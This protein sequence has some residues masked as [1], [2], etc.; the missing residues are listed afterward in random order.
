MNRL[1]AILITLNEERNLPR[2]LDSLA[3][4]PDEILVVDAGSTD[5]TREIAI[6]RGARVTER[7]WTNYSDQRNFAASQA[8]FDWILALDADEQLSPLLLD[9][10]RAWRLRPPAHAAY[11]FPRRARYLGKWIR[12]SGWYPD[13]KTRLYDRRRARFVGLV[14]EAVQSDGPVGQLVGDLLHYAYETPAEHAAKVEAYTTIAAQ[15]LFRAAKR[16]WFLPMLLV[17]LWTLV[18]KFILRAGFL[19]GWRGWRIARM[20]ARYAWLKFKKLGELVRNAKP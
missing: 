8:R 18:Q 2:A 19:D 20:S 3:D 16:S 7:A 12:H 10:L 13:R 17:P 5:R 6:Q 14:H 1:T 11:E 15:E 4:L 9:S